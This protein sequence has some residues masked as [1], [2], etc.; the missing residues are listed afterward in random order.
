MSNS[1]DIV[2]ESE[3]MEKERRQGRRTRKLDWWTVRGGRA[4]VGCS[5]VE[6]GGRRP[7]SRERPGPSPAC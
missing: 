3:G 1:S 5:Y 6:E 2:A 4:G 7:G